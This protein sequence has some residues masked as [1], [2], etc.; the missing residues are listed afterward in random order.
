MLHE[1]QKVNN[2]KKLCSSAWFEN[3]PESILSFDGSKPVTISKTVKLWG[4][5]QEKHYAFLDLFH[6]VINM[7]ITITFYKKYKQAGFD[8]VIQNY[9]TR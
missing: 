6:N 7:P 2:N 5:M 1:L 4:L 3:H 9:P 8:N